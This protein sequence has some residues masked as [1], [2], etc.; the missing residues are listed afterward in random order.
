M[1][2]QDGKL[3]KDS[4]AGPGGSHGKQHEY[5]LNGRDK[6]HPIVKGLPLKWRH[7]QDELYDRMRSRVISETCFIRLIRIKRQEVQDVKNRLSLPSITEMPVSS[8]PCSDMPVLLLKIIQLCSVQASRFCYC[9]VR[10]GLQPEGNSESTQ[11]FPDR[12][13]VQLPEGL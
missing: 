13:T 10:N 7:T 11:R 6:I 8:I 12:D 1:Y 4:S 3:V 5:V 9:V 2:W